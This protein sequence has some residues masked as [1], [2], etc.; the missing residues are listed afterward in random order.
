MTRGPV[1]LAALFAALTLGAVFAT[2]GVRE[3]R[4]SGNSV[5][6]SVDNRNAAAG[7]AELPFNRVLSVPA[8]VESSPPLDIVN[9]EFRSSTLDQGWR[10][11]GTAPKDW[12]VGGTPGSLKITT[13]DGDLYADF[14]DAKGVLLRQ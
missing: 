10:F 13:E 6:Y 5:P 3:T 4:A 2:S 14:N 9:D 1:I 11:S 8:L 7:V 12:S